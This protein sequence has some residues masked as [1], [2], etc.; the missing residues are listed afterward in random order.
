MH[1]VKK[2]KWYVLYTKT[3][4]DKERWLKAFKKERELA[5]K[6]KLGNLEVSNN[7]RKDIMVTARTKKVSIVKPKSKG[8][9]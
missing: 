2:K 4:G 6:E 5:E 8:L 3:P 9:C 1:N 7:K